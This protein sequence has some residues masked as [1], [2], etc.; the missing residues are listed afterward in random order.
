MNF[1]TIFLL[2]IR[3]I[4]YYNQHQV[5]IIVDDANRLTGRAAALAAAHPPA[6]AWAPA[7]AR[8]DSAIPRV[9]PLNINPGDDDVVPGHFLCPISFAIMT[10]PVTAGDGYTYDRDSIT[11]AL[12]INPISP[13]TRAPMNAHL[14][15]P[16]LTLR[17]EMTAWW[18][19]LQ[20]TKKTAAAAAAAAADAKRDTAAN[21]IQ[22]WIR[23]RTSKI[24]R[25]SNPGMSPNGGSR[26]KRYNRNRRHHRQNR[27][28]SSHPPI[29]LHLQPNRKRQRQRNRRRRLRRH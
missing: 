6:P 19:D 7:Q 27:R 8:I 17:G 10:D 5:G 12:R 29:R 11:Q 21:R 13:M 3:N 15:I 2:M 24:K 9:R 4:R 20:R 16:N 22:K 25:A 23:T 26:R 14:L 1:G 18:D 28:I